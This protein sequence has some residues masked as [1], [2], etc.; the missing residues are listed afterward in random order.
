MPEELKVIPYSDEYKEAVR[1]LIFDI[2]ENELGHHSKT[3]RPDLANIKEVYQINKGNFWVAVKD[4]ELVGTIALKDMGENRGDLWR[5]YVKKNLR[6]KGIGHKL[7]S[8]LIGFARDKEYKQIFLSTHLDQEAA[9]RFY[10]KH[11]FKRINSLPADFAH[12]PKDEIFYEL[13][14]E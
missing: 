11:G 8:I 4:G 10:L 14:L 3:G 2:A 1:N 7:F 12:S 13:D 9:N 6:K 5:F